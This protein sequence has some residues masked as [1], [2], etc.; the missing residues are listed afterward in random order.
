MSTLAEDVNSKASKLKQPKAITHIFLTEMWERFSYYGIT[1]LLIL[2]MSK[3][4]GLDKNQVYAIYG[5]YGALIYMTP[6]IGGAIAD[7]FW[8]SYFSIIVGAWFIAIGHFVVSIPAQ[9][10]QYFYLGLAIIIVGTG[11][12]TPNINTVVGHLYD[13]NDS[14]RDSGFTLAYMGRNIGTILAPIV[15][16]EVAAV[17]NWRLAFCLAGFGMLL[18]IWTFIKG[19][20]HYNPKSLHAV[21]QTHKPSGLKKLIWPG[22]LLLVALVYWAMQHVQV[23]GIALFVVV[24]VMLF[25][26][27]VVLVRASNEVKPKMLA[28][29]VLTGFYIVFMILLQQSGGAL[30][31]FT[32]T[33]VNRMW[34][35]YRLETGFFQS[36]EPLA[37]ILLT[38]LFRRM[39]ERL[40]QQG[41]AVP[42]GLKFVIAL[43][44]MSSS[45]AILALAVNFSDIHGKI[46]MSWI[47]FVYL[48]Q[49]AGELF[50]GPIGLAMVTRLIPQQ[51]IGFYMG[52][53]VLASAI[54][55]FSAAKIGAWV[56]PSDTMMAANLPL[57][58]QAY[59]HAFASIALFGFVAAILLWMM[60]P[61]L[62]RLTRT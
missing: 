38:P 59:Q 60:N 40:A 57:Q 45:F 11:L 42:D 34:M 28:A 50:I 23:V 26:L 53:W 12:F 44:L 13:E 21:R 41:K 15:C 36:V 58:M 29:L 1:A 20:P 8:G 6:I 62:R 7:K 52:V 18:G 51:M 16:A 31:L 48:L 30:N 32:D 25:I 46:A 61:Y 9:G 33:N 35:G 10:F 4:F 39:W 54:A 43:V 27:L 14:Q 55:N 22:L 3:T 17:Y 47:N 24:S 2:Y 37:L 5:A 56:T 19:K 49:A